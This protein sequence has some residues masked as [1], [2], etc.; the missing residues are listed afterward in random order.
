MPCDVNLQWKNM[1]VCF[2]FYCQCNPEYPQ[3]LDGE[4]LSLQQF[5]CGAGHDCDDETPPCDPD[6]HGPFCGKTWHLANQ[7]WAHA[8]PFDAEHGYHEHCETE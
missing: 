2:D 8:G 5:T 6:E 3:H 4:G 1:E 7:A